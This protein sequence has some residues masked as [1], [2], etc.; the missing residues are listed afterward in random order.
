SQNVPKARVSG[1]G[2]ERTPVEPK[3]GIEPETSSLPRKCSTAEL[4]GRKPPESGR[5]KTSGFT[6]RPRHDKSGARWSELTDSNRQQSPWKGD[7]LPIELSSPDHTPRP[8]LAQTG[9]FHEFPAP[10]GHTTL[11]ST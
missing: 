4:F 2:R 8:Y 9:N 5:T 11:P 3:S 10:R 7:T 1:A 6:A